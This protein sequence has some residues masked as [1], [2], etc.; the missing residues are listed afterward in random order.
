MQS[1]G[2][3]RIEATPPRGTPAAPDPTSLLT[4]GELGY[5]CALCPEHKHWSAEY[6]HSLLLPPVLLRQVRI[7]RDDRK[8]PRAAMLWAYLSD[9]LHSQLRDKGKPFGPKGW[10]T[11]SHLWLMDVIAPFGHG[12]D[13]GR[14]IARMP[15]NRT[16]HYLRMWPDR[17]VRRVVEC[18]PRR[19]RRG[20]IEVARQFD[21]TGS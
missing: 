12:R 6:L 15:P 21:R 1:H 20:L 8:A 9:E 2:W 19:G 11:G 3:N 14:V 7:F 4:L 5:L 17:T 16:F 18:D 10:N 13:V